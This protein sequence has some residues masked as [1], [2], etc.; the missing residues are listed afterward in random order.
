M[1]ASR[2]ARALAGGA[3]NAK[4]FAVPGGHFA[5]PPTPSV[6]SRLATMRSG[7]RRAPFTWANS[8]RPP[9]PGRPYCDPGVTSPTHPIV[10]VFARFA[11]WAGPAAASAGAAGSRPG[12]GVSRIATAASAGARIAATASS[13]R[14]AERSTRTGFGPRA[15]VSFRLHDRVRR[16]TAR[17]SPVRHRRVEDVGDVLL[18]DLARRTHEQPLLLHRPVDERRDVVLAIAE[19]GDAARGVDVLH[20]PAD[21]VRQGVGAGVLDALAR[22]PLGHLVVT[23]GYRLVREAEGGRRGDDHRVAV[24]DERV[25]VGVAGRLVGV[26]EAGDRV[27]AGVRDVDA[28]AAEADAGHRRA[29]HHPAAGLEVVVVGDGAP[30]ELA[31]VLERLRRP[32]VGDRVRALVGRAVIGG[33]GALAAVVRPGEVALG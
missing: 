28:G 2:S 9:C 7:S 26:L 33:L 27:R 13:G 15:C 1:P 14:R 18:G 3:W 8:A 19:L 31:A 30:Q 21:H 25:V 16:Y 4:Q 22:E 6:P 23:L 12:A 24:R 11:R 5:A 10:S 32:H 20:E 29:E 17:L